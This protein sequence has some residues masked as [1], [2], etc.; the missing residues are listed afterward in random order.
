VVLLYLDVLEGDAM[1]VQSK[2]SRLKKSKKKSKKSKNK[3]RKVEY[4]VPVYRD[5]MIV[6]YT[7]VEL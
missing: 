2:K 1:S 5:G 6:A 4:W 3:Q 7:A